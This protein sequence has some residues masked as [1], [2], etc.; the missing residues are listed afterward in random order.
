M[1]SE[2]IP[3]NPAELLGSDYFKKLIE[4]LNL[5]EYST[6]NQPLMLVSDS[7]E[8]IKYSDIVV[9]TVRSGY[10]DNKIIPFIESLIQDKKINNIGFVLCY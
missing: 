10:T 5:H 2:T 7:F 4:N 6:T 3:P 1:Y 9:Y 8:L